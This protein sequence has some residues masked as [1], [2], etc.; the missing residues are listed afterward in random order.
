MFL[1]YENPV[2]EYT[3]SPDQNSLAPAHHPLVIVGA[4]PIG[5]GA[6]LD[7]H[8]QG[9]P[10]V[11]LD[12]NNTVSVGSRAVCYSKR[13]LEILNRLGCARRMVEKGV[14]W[15]VGKVFFQDELVTSF[16]LLPEEGH[17]I[18]AFINLQQYYLEEYMVDGLKDSDNVEIR[19]K[20]KVV[21]VENHSAAGA[22]D[23]TDHQDKPITLTIE[24]PD[25]PYQITTDWL[26]VAD[27]ANSSVRNMLDLAMRGKVFEDRFLI[28][29]IVM[30]AEFP[31]ER[32]FSFDPSYHPNQSTLL[33][34]QSDN[35]WRL[36]FQ[37]GWD[38]DPEEEKKPE[39]IIPRVKAMMGEDVDFELEWASVY[40][41]MCRRM[42]RFRQGRVI[43]A[44]DAAHQV[45]PFGARGANS[46]LQD[47]DNLLWKLK[48]VMEGK[49]P[50]ALIDSY[51]DEREYA[52]DENLLNSTR[53]TDFIT[54]KSK[55][56][57]LFRDS[58]LELSKEYHF[59]QKLVNSGRLSDAAFLTE[60]VLN[61][62]DRDNFAGNMVPGAVM[63]D[64]PIEGD[65]QERW[66][67][68]VFGNRFQLLYFI[69]NASTLDE[70]TAKQ[71]SSLEQGD[72]PVQA[73]VVATSG[74]A[75]QNLKTVIDIKGMLATR[76]D[77]QNGTCYLAR[78][79]QHVA[80][81]WRSFELPN[82]QKAVK[83]A[84]CN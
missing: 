43:F 81:R 17:E 55:V 82:V 22:Q 52:A 80:A 26:I 45:S 44:G 66:A 79:D 4:G 71:L 2:Y 7:A 18:P 14:T 58:T 83:T 41:F 38:K 61:T 19:W 40:T 12:D 63:D 27:G 77:A 49:A 20:N 39:N 13:A 23:G 21:D 29:D 72:I 50:D 30:K 6:A 74:T 84:T 9:I 35:V 68:N 67:L 31:P 70:Q 59:A 56:S 64:A 24:T 28:A 51:C 16:D 57:K 37:L 3:K 54:P 60:S 5:M 1:T 65:Q 10:A 32:W 47:T 48:L 42:D 73:V 75:P 53:S 46:G 62:A 25:G 8:L 78:P 33:H 36:D 11:V 34:R 76:Y 15:K 69:D